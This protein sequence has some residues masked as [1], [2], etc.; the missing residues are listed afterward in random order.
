MHV[1]HDHPARP[2]PS[3]T[4]RPGRHQQEHRPRT[5]YSLSTG[6]VTR[7]PSRSIGRHQHLPAGRGA[8]SHR[9]LL[10]VAGEHQHARTGT[11]DHGRQTV[12]AQSS[13]QR[14]RRRHGRLTELLVQAVLGGR[15]QQ[16]G[17]AAQRR[18]QERRATGVRSRIGVRHGRGQQVSRDRGLHRVRGHE[19]DHLHPGV[20]GHG[21]RAKAAGVPGRRSCTHRRRRAPRCP[22]DPRA[23]PRAR[24]R[25]RRPSA[26]THR[27]PAHAPGTPLPRSRPTRIRG[28]EHAV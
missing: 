20:H 12:G 27:P 16:L 21:C 5:G 13:D 22:G 6:S 18:H 3:I 17:L 1:H 28:R 8:A 2:K 14:Q 9:L 19:H 4:H 11:G 26:A 25:R 24:T 7:A 10:V 15:Q 23:R